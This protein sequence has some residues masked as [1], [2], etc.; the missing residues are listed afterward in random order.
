MKR[1]D[2]ARRLQNFISL[3]ENTDDS[4]YELNCGPRPPL[5]PASYVEVLTSVLHNATSF[6]CRIVAN[7]IKV[8]S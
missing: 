4:C 5:P 2:K 3:N 7:V 1:S 6:G 8:R